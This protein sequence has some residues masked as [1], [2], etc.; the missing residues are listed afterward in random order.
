MV[1]QALNRLTQKHTPDT[2][3]WTKGQKVWLN[4]K[5]LVLPYRTIK[6]A[7]RR[8]GPFTIEE[9]RSPVVYKLHL[10]PQWNIHPVFHASLLTPY[11]ETVEHG[12]NYSRPPPDMIKG[13]E[14]YEV[15]AVRAHRRHR[16]K[17][18]YLIKWKG[19]PESDNIWEPVDNVQAPLLI[20]KYHE[21]HP[22]EDKRPAKR[23]RVA[24]SPTTT[25]QPT[26]LLDN[27]HQSTFNDATAVAVT[28]AV[29][30]AATTT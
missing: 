10:P 25:P 18:Q 20:R 14:Q 2:P 23:A 16:R 28:L 21:T 22:L 6:L 24:S 1:T 15:E 17:L 29:T 13:E 9:V 12:E 11:I 26:W 5:N 30:V 4:T 7:P 19:Y 27:D 3:R 8:H